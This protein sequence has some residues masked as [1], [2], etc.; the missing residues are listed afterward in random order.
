MSVNSASPKKQFL[1]EKRKAFAFWGVRITPDCYGR[2]YWTSV[3]RF[4]GLGIDGSSYR[5]DVL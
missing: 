4:N 5:L 1:W 3:K 2:L